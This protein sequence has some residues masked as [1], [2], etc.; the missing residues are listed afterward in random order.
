MFRSRRI[1][2]DSSDDDF[3]N[4]TDLLK[5]NSKRAQ[6]VGDII[7]TPAH[8]KESSAKN[9]TVR[10]RKLGAVVLD[11]PL[12]RPLSGQRSSSSST[13]FDEVDETPRKRVPT[14][15]SRIELM[16]RKTNPVVKGLER[17][18]SDS[19]EMDSVQEETIL[20][21][22]SEGSDDDNGN[23][24][25]SDFEAIQSE[26]SDDD[27]LAEFLSWSPSKSKRA[28]GRTSAERDET[29]GRKTKRSPSPGAQLLAEAIEAQE[30]EQKQTI[31]KGG[32]INN[33][34]TRGSS[35]ANSDLADPL[36]KLRM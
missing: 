28:A 3:P 33:E 36:F 22:F 1:V 20:E 17:D 16:K 8:T 21:N 24:D 34:A 31:P 26:D 12:M 29:Q 15:L 2:D 35:N 27:S 19:S 5:T 13:L 11:N 6:K 30:R 10:R 25:E 7:G 23:D 4:I 32:K 14:T 9:G 18:E